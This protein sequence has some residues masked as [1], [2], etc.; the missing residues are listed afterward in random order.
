MDFCVDGY[1]GNVLLSNIIRSKLYGEFSKEI[2]RKLDSNYPNVCEIITNA[3]SVTKL[4]QP[5]EKARV[6]T[7]N[8]N[9][10][11][12][13]PLRDILKLVTFRDNQARPYGLLLSTEATEMLLSIYSFNSFI[14]NIKLLWSIF[15]HGVELRRG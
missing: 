1:P 9:S 11:K 15:Q 3:T 5:R 2:C 13:A 12:D 10:S 7:V 4:K 8:A 6:V 14:L